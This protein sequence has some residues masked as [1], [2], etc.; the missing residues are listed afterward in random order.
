MFTSQVT[1]M[2]TLFARRRSRLFTRCA[3][4]LAL[5]TKHKM[6]ILKKNEENEKK[7]SFCLTNPV[8]YYEPVYRG[9]MKIEKKVNEQSFLNTNFRKIIKTR[10]F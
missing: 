1:L 3:Q 9:K 4:L 6:E 10:I 7:L 5:R 2:F 8:C